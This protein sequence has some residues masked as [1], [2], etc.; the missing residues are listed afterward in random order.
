MRTKSFAVVAAVAIAWSGGASARILM[1]GE[2]LSSGEVMYSED[3]HY[4]ATMQPD[5]N[6]VVYKNETPLRLIWSTGT[7]GRGAVTAN[8][9]FDGN[10]VLYDA[11]GHAV[12]DTRSWGRDRVFTVTEF[13][14][15]MI[16]APGKVKRHQPG[17]GTNLWAKL[18]FKPVWIAKQYDRVPGR[19][20]D[21][22]YCI[23]DPHACGR[24]LHGGLYQGR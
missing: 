21:G 2:H 19:L 1:P 15:A 13:G 14:Q 7:T 3:G 8:M 10:F 12:W 6:F 18:R 11:V 17:P 4:L 20:G 23:G 5:G 16:M 22:P 9:Q 24:K